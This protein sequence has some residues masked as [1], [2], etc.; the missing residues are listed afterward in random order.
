MIAWMLVAVALAG[1]VLNVRQDR[2]C[3]WLWVV[4]NAGLMLVH[5]KQKQWAQA[6]MFAVYLL[7]AVWGLV[8]W[9]KEQG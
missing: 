1:T 3:F 8:S 4:S 6:T 2:R 5:A 9:R 7:L